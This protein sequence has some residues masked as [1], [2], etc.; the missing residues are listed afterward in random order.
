MENTIRKEYVLENLCCGNCAAQIEREA[1]NLGGVKRANVDIIS[2]TLAL[3]LTDPQRADALRGEIEV[4]ARRHDSDIVLREKAMH[5]PGQQTL[6]LS[7]LDCAACALKIENAVKALDG[8]KSASVDFATQR[9]TVE[10]R[11]AAALPTLLRNA[12]ETARR[13]EPNVSI[14]Y[15]EQKA[16]PDEG[17][18]RFARAALIGGAALFVLGFVLPL[19]GAGKFIFFLAAYLLAGWKVLFKAARNITK[20]RVFDENFLMSIAS[21]GAFSIGEYPEGAAVML[22][23]QAGE[24]LQ[25]IAVDRSRDSIASLMNIRPDYANLKLGDEIKKVIPEEVAEGDIIVVRPGER[26][27]LDGVVK[28][29][30]SAIDTSALTGESLPRDVQPGSTVL[31]GSVNQG[32]LLTVEVTK[33]YG[34][35]TVA[36]ILELV[37]NAGSQKAKA[38]HFITK[39]ARYYTPVVVFSSLALALLPPLLLPG[40]PFAEWIRRALVFLVVSCPCALV[41]SV[42]LGFFAGIGGA[43]KSGVLIKGGNY[44]E[45]LNRV[46][47]VVFDKTGTLTRG[48]FQVTEAAPAA[49]FSRESLLEL[50]AHAESYSSHPIAVS[51][52]EAY[53]KPVDNARLADVEELA[54][55]GVCVKVDEKTV[56]AGN[57]RLMESQHIALPENN[58]AGTVV[59]LA[60]DGTY[61]GR[62]V[63]ADAV[64]P[65]SRDAIR[66]LKA[67]GV[68]RT[69]M[70][71][72]D[73]KAAGERVG[74]ALGLDEIHAELLPQQKVEQL[75][76]L[77]VKSAG[78]G[79]LVFVGDGINDAPVL[80]RADVGVAMGGL[81]S[82]AAIEAADVVL[83]TDEPTRLAAAIHIARRT[84]R[85][86]LQNIVF[87]LAVK[88]VFL[89]LGA[90][91]LANMWEAV[92]GDVGVTLIAVLNATRAMRAEK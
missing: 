55:H 50:A 57:A 29:G 53:G 21:I 69:V 14:S 44:L 35:S 8:V 87:A 88:G 56:L 79:S 67:A 46:D 28:E 9:I 32:G 91:G 18:E 30:A 51:I 13:L 52:R 7:G 48:T 85:I 37:Q 68:R 74:G 12:A 83:M 66:A 26:V 4:I 17:G 16:Q 90:L 58:A 25:D 63:I 62:L 1:G 34:E 70:L 76:R 60:V 49:G 42:P 71:T 73:S 23:Y 65:D 39:F 45:A 54:G 22:F 2:K 19:P 6:Y 84:H 10:A 89:T 47:T 64:K 61:A 81:G 31:S 86:V 15:T 38:E 27:P 77:A 92:F 40:A 82:D 11:D 59:Y 5:A 78:R 24:L 80:A 43:S 33:G 41:V 75:E 72:G 3:D 20:G 36:R